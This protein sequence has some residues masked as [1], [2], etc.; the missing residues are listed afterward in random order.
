MKKVLGI[1]F[2]SVT[3]LFLCSCG[4]RDNADKLVFPKTNWGMSV[5]ETL[6][7]YG[8]TKEDTSSYE[9]YHKV[10][11]MTVFTINGHELFGENTAKIIFNFIDLGGSG[12]QVLCE[13]KVIYPQS[14]DMDHVL[15]EMKKAY[16]ETVSTFSIYDGYQLSNNSLIGIEYQDSE[17]TKLWAGSPIAE[18]I[19]EKESES[20]RNLWIDFQPNL[21][22]DNWDMF[23]QN[24]R[25]VAVVWSHKEDMNM[26]S[27]YAYNLAV[28]NHLNSQLS[29]QQ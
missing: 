29:E 28:Y 26:L 15:E 2:L 9:E 5:E 27:F 16:G 6:D 18:L 13:I 23:S 24:A 1:I 17:N 4:E 19:P 20:Y 14:T 7:A 21:N 3:L 25:T 8:I 11:E 22:A 12:S 10:V